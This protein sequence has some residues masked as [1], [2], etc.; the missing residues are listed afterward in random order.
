MGLNLAII[1]HLDSMIKILL[2][3]SLLFFALAINGQ[4][5][6]T[7]TLEAELK[8]ARTSQDKMVL[9]YQL[10]T[11]YLK[12]NKKK[13]EDHAYKAALL[14]R[15]LGD[16]EMAARA[17]SVNA[18]A[19]LKGRDRK[20]AKSRFKTSFD[21]AKRTKDPALILEIL[22]LAV[23]TEKKYGS[24]KAAYAYTEDAL[25]IIRDTK[26]ISTTSSSQPSNYSAGPSSLVKENRVLEA[27]KQALEADILQLQRE[28]AKF[29]TDQSSLTAQ[30]KQLET[31]KS[32]IEAEKSLIEAEKN[33]VVETIAKKEAQINKMSK[34]QL[35]AKA[36]ILET[37]KVVSQLKLKKQEQ[38]L[39]LL[40]SRERSGY[41]LLAT[42]LGLFLTLFLFLRYR[43]NRKAKKVLV[44]K[45]KLIEEERE[46]SD[47]LLKNILPANI[48]EE[49]KESGKAKAQRYENATVMFSDFKNFTKISE[50]LSPEDLVKEL[51]ICFR[52]FDQIISQYD[53]EK[54]K[55]I[56][57]AYMVASGLTDRYSVPVD[58]IKAAMDM[59]EF[60]EDLKKEKIRQGLPYFEARIGMGD[61]VNIAARM[62]AN[63]EPGQIN[64][65]E[66]TYRLVKYNF[67]CHYRGKINAKNK[68]HIDM[69]Y[70][71]N[72]VNKVVPSFA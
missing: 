5:K 41:L 21:Y 18:Q 53:V 4:S 48:A 61:T 37:E 6:N 28:K 51:D 1:V 39:A 12:S 55:T 16:P 59:Q 50:Q 3:Y 42:T 27:Q 45:N 34:E 11:A 47:D 23:A 22:E 58:I 72:K 10:G 19:K 68:G 14:A 46:R 32:N 31:A 67:N 43:S 40:K 24:Y 33:Q 57:D 64:I 66:E 70:V 9:N 69:Y 15:E 71:E 29:S 20:G 52:G 49:L 62:E 8:K 60:L 36:K 2:T 26:K 65:S 56:G 38:D 63:C 35:R 30:Q 25:E 54:I 44:E 17:Y 13:A 7:K